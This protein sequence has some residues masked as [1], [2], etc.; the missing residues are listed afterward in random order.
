[1]NFK[2]SKRFFSSALQVVSRAI[3]ANSP[4]PSMSGIKIDIYFDKIILTGTNSN[5]SIQRT[6]V[7][8]DENNL[9]VNEEGC[10]VLEAKYIL[11]IVRKIDSDTVLFET[12]DGNLIKISGHLAQYKLNAINYSEYPEISFSHAGQQ[13]QID[14]S[15][16]V[17]IIN[18]TSFATSDKETKPVLTG[19]NF[20]C[21]G[22]LLECTATDSY[23]LARKVVTLDKEY[24]FNITIPSK[25]LNEIVKSIDKDCTITITVSDKQAEF[26]VD[27]T[28]IQTRLLDGNYPDTERLIPTEFAY[29]M[30]VDSRDILN[31]IDR[32]LFIKSDGI[33]IVRLSACENDVILSTK[34]QEV[35]SSTEKLD[36]IS[37]HGEPLEIS[38]SGKY[39]FE[40]I[41]TL[42]SSVVTFSFSGP[43]RPFII[44]N[45]EDTS[46]LQLVLPV[47]TY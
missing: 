8:D 14:A 22:N 25:N 23:R 31:A 11:E 20:K 42:D 2:I 39:V 6:I 1:M 9:L 45:T 37:Y 41:R 15:L 32:T 13:F 44:K 26:Y 38:F 40:A 4:V 16:L 24:N 3:T 47:R 5:I 17:N 12:L 36:V 34:S 7:A 29:E 30:V 46:I 10:I 35:G 19:V 21:K 43:M 28:I 18:Q 27:N 33:S